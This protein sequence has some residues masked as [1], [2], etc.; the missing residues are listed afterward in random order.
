MTSSTAWY[1]RPGWTWKKMIW[2]HLT[3]SDATALVPGRPRSSP[4]ATG[5]SS[6][7]P[8]H[9]GSQP[10]RNLPSSE[11]AVNSDSGASSGEL[12]RYRI[13]EMTRVEIESSWSR[14]WEL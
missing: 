13:H 14:R 5:K 11:G 3:G 1:D 10:L 6:S 12:G 9:L 7:E 2:P 4:L 8:P